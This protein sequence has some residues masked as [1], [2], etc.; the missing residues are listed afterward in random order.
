MSLLSELEQVDRRPTHGWKV[1]LISSPLTAVSVSNLDHHKRESPQGSSEAQSPIIIS[2]AKLATG[3][4]LCVTPQVRVKKLCSSSWRSF[5]SP[6]KLE[7]KTL[8][9]AKGSETKA[10]S[11]IKQ[12]TSSS[13][14]SKLKDKG[15]VDPVKPAYK[16]LELRI[17]GND[18]HDQ[19]D[20]RELK[21]SS[22][23]QNS[24]SCQ[25]NLE[26]IFPETVSEVVRVDIDID[27][28]PED[29]DNGCENTD[30]VRQ[31]IVRQTPPLTNS[32]LNKTRPT[33]VK[34]NSVIA[35]TEERCSSDAVLRSREKT[36]S[37]RKVVES[38]N[39]KSKK[40]WN[41][42]YCPLPTLVSFDNQVSES[43]Y[44]IRLH[45][46]PQVKVSLVQKGNTGG[47]QMNNRFQS[48]KPSSSSY[49]EI[50]SKVYSVL[51]Q[52]TFKLNKGTELSKTITVSNKDT[53]PIAHRNSKEMSEISDRSKPSENEHNISARE[54]DVFSKSSFDSF[55]D[56]A[57][58]S[59]L[60]S[61]SLENK[62]LYCKEENLFDT[63]KANDPLASKISSPTNP[64]PSKGSVKE[65]KV[66][67]I[68]TAVKSTSSP[69]EGSTHNSPAA[70]SIICKIKENKTSDDTDLKGSSQNQMDG[71]NGV[72]G[73][74]GPNI[75][76][77]KNKMNCVVCGKQSVTASSG[78]K[79]VEC[80]KLKHVSIANINRQNNTGSFYGNSHLS[81]KISADI[82]SNLAKDKTDCNYSVLSSSKDV[83]KRSRPASGRCTQNKRKVT[84]PE[85]VTIVSSDE[86]DEDQSLMPE[87]A[88]MPQEPDM[89]METET[90]T[91]MNKPASAA[92][93]SNRMKLKGG[94]VC[95]ESNNNRS[96]ALGVEMG[97]CDC[98][99]KVAAV[100]FGNLACR[101]V[102]ELLIN[103]GKI[104][105]ELETETHI[106]GETW[107]HSFRLSMSSAEIQ[108]IKIHV[109]RSPSMIVI[110]PSHKFTNDVNNSFEDAIFDPNSKTKYQIVILLEFDFNSSKEAQEIYD[111]LVRNL[112]KIASYEPVTHKQAEH[113]LMEAGQDNFS[114]SST[115]KV[116]DTRSAS[117]TD[118][119]SELSP[120]EVVTLLVYSP[121]SGPGGIAITNEDLSCLEEGRYLNDTIIDFY[122]KYLF[123]TK[124][125]KETREKTYI[126][127]SYF[128]KR[129]TQQPGGGANAA[130]MMHSQ[131]KKWTRNVD[132][133]NKDF[134]L[135]P[136]NEH[137][138]WYLVVICFP[139]LAACIEEPSGKKDN[140]FEG[141]VTAEDKMDTSAVFDNSSSESNVMLEEP[142]D[143]DSADIQAEEGNAITGNME[144]TENKYFGGMNT[145]AENTRPNLKIPKN[146]INN[147]AEKVTKSTSENITK[148]ITEKDTKSIP[149]NMTKNTTKV[150]KDNPEKVTKNTSAQKAESKP[151][152]PYPCILIFDSLVT[153]GHVR[154]FIN[155]RQYLTVEWEAK[156]GKTEGRKEFT[157]VNMKGSFPKVPMQTNDCDCGVY[158]LQY[159][160][161]F[162]ESPIKNFH[163]TIKMEDWFTNDRVSR[164]RQELQELIFDLTT[165]YEKEVEK[166]EK[167]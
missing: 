55:D 88:T 158:V 27:S 36:V 51:S 117:K 28:D 95:N 148:E 10:S 39:E 96:Y 116:Y 149:E 162:F 69:S 98:S 157:K 72:E 40:K 58:P 60:K 165:E 38:D 133:F 93:V 94:K 85:C 125:D 99:V 80:E 48:M 121:V 46:E 53:V 76:Q 100:H 150:T 119:G 122:L 73:N 153:G 159:A 1:G 74:E 43:S 15:N 97:V 47:A 87:T 57:S 56:R 102:S 83:K 141:K 37:L 136:I 107:K 61:S 31:R 52:E 32:P 155:L 70:D 145:Y 115:R 105:I 13:K 101:A 90:N 127:S 54:S 14:N 113:I 112:S 132:I 134:I 5:K 109:G 3:T 124:L 2:D 151:K 161:S 26:E 16:Q 110:I 135:I 160:E 144:G 152:G 147:I 22:N 126:F 84:R 64:S 23:P 12:V 130:R 41:N 68:M 62:D 111:K 123:H 77:Y 91:S 139:R 167:K 66:L 71:M 166:T 24:A 142:M 59:T 30:F 78:D 86:E 131:V 138:H 129:L 81:T 146:I 6:V 79:C 82:K 128:Y 33:L 67:G 50:K 35:I 18:E 120:E 108:K 154:V 163:S 20:L 4:H 75:N 7:N 11:E 21:H 25:R 104:F 103:D 45:D 106:Q 63:D 118:P 89:E 29:D 65:N 140:Q 114:Q 17:I 164:K 92:K 137:S 19:P 49:G 9:S 34:E 42:R 156:R 8:D 143:T 44:R